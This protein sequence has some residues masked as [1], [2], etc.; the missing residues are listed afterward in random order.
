[1]RASAW[2]RT[3]C[4]SCS[5]GSPESMVLDVWLK[6]SRSRCD[7]RHG[8]HLNQLS[9]VHAQARCRLNVQAKRGRA[10]V[11][12]YGFEGAQCL[13]YVFSLIEKQE[14]FQPVA[15]SQLLSGHNYRS[16]K[17]GLVVP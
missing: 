17:G 6:R 12:T 16:G 4:K 2:S 8:F 14:V 3:K 9:A 10:G 5:C 13:A 15:E 1:M 7:V 11:L